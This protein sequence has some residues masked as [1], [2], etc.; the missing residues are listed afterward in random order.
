MDLFHET[1][2]PIVLHLPVFYP[3]KNFCSDSGGEYLSD[4]FRQFLT[5]EGTLAQ[6]SCLVAHAQNG[7][8]ERKHRHLIETARTILISSFV[9][10]HFW[11]KLF[12][13]QSISLIGSHHPNCLENALMKYVLV[14]HLAMI[15]LEFLDA[16]AMFCLCLVKGLSGLHSFLSVFFW[17]IVLSIRVIGVMILLL[18]VC[19]SHVM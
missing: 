15:I 11:V 12:L 2:F 18:A 10:S 8:V 3:Y 5:S 19:V 14:L 7:V 16:C 13:L 17:A 4:V 9:P 6:L 1:S